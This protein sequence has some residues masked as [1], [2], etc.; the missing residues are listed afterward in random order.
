M[1]YRLLKEQVTRQEDGTII[2][3]LVATGDIFKGTPEA[4]QTETE[5]LQST[6]GGCYAAEAIPE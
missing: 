6:E 2:S 4:A 5:R 1:I 3:V